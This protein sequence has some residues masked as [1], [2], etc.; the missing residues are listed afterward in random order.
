M[1]R[2]PTP[3]ERDTFAELADRW[4]RFAA[5]APAVPKP[6]DEWSDPARASQHGPQCDAPID[7]ETAP[8]CD[9]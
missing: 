7:S 6:I 1:T 2:E 5:D 3:E 9:Q 4:E 8:Y